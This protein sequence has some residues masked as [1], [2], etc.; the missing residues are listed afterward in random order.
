MGISN[1]FRVLGGS[2]GVAI[3][4][5]ILNNHITD[6]L[7]GILDPLQIKA[8]LASVQALELIP[9]EQREVVREAFTASFIQQ[10]Q[11]ILGLSGAGLL[12]TLL[13]VERRPRFQH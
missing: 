3:C 7:H 1:Q 9:S 10:M 6:R 2:I 4:A 13:M 8:L 12:L 11:I 5:N